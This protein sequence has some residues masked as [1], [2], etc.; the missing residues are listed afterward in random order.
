[1]EERIDRKW[2]DLLLSGTSEFANQQS[3]QT[4]LRAFVWVIGGLAIV[5]GGVGMLNAQLMAIFERTREIGVLR[6]T[7]WKRHQVL[8]MILG[9]SL[10]VCLAGG[11]FG[12]LQGW[13]LLKGAFTDHGAD[14]DSNRNDLPG[15]CCPGYECG[16]SPWLGRWFIPGLAGLPASAGGGSAL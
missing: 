5:I 15:T 9:E 1:V 11:L 2:P 12:I 3:M 13:L 16:A 10:V 8:G 7:G 6:A 4:I 14:G